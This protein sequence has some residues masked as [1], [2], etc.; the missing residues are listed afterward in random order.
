MKLLL[1]IE[2]R[3]EVNGQYYDH[4]TWFR[5]L[6]RKMPSKLFLILRTEPH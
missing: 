4:T 1:D 6:I 3:F 2:E 5:E